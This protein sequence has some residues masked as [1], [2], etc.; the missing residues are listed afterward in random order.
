MKLSIRM[1]L[2]GASML[3]TLSP[4][5][6]ARVIFG[7]GVYVGGPVY[8][9]WGYYSP[10]YG[11]AYRPVYVA[12]SHHGEGQLKLDTTD[13]NATVY[14]D[15]AYAGSVHDIHSPWLSEGN[16]DVE[17]RHANGDRFHEQIHITPGNTLHLHV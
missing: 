12:P 8:R 9:P 1:M 15:G 10:W 13:Q 3:V 6:Q 7:G 17:V 11:P 5:A 4:L 2:L 16:H 14:I